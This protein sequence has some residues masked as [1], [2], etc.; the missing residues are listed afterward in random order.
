MDELHTI[1]TPFLFVVVSQGILSQL[2]HLLIIPVWRTSSYKN[3]F[4]P[5]VIKQWN[6]LPQSYFP[7]ISNLKKSTE[8]DAPISYLLWEFTISVYGYLVYPQLPQSL[9]VIF[10]DK[11][12]FLVTSIKTWIFL[13]INTHPLFLYIFTFF[14][15]YYQME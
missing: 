1:I 6:S 4:P 12:T 14:H 7:D 2:R 5:H 3:Y 13:Q 15:I 10:K 11:T 8:K 9:L